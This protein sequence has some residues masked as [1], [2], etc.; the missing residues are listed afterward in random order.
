[1]VIA[2]ILAAGESARLGTPKQ[3]VQV[4][5][6]TLIVHAVEAALGSK[7]SSAMVIMGA[8][9]EAV[10]REIV[11]YKVQIVRNLSWNEGKASSI[12]TAVQE[13]MRVHPEVSGILFL[14]CD[15]PY[16]T[17]EVLDELLNR[18]EI[19]GDAAVAAQY[20]DT[21]GIPAIVPRRL[22]AELLQLRGDHGAQL[23]L[24]SPGD[25]LIT[26]QFPLGAVDIDCAEDVRNLSDVERSHARK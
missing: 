6:K 16:V 19:T 23:I 26:V 22:F 7:C 9:A 8:N 11:Q 18:F 21:I 1:M 15:Q 14:T 3:T 25:D 12:R 24:R 17:S 2:A 20:A 4:G 5:G 13:A 10:E